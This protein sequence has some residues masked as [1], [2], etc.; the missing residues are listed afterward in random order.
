A[1]AE[2]ENA[3]IDALY[4]STLY[5]DLN[6]AIEKY[7][8]TGRPKII[9][10][11]IDTRIARSLRSVEGLL[12]QGHSRRLNDGGIETQIKTIDGVTYSIKAWND[13]SQTRRLRVGEVEFAPPCLVGRVGGYTFAIPDR[14]DLQRMI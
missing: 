9:H 10:D 3:P 5:A 8:S 4:S 2:F 12:R 14:H 7:K 1:R 6:R 11:A 13:R